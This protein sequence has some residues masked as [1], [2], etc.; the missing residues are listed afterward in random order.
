MDSKQLSQNSSVTVWPEKL[1][2]QREVDDLL[3]KKGVSSSETLDE[4]HQDARIINDKKKSNDKNVA[5]LVKKSNR[6]LTSISTHGWP[7]DFFP[8]TLNVEEGRI[9]IIIR[10]LF[11]SEVHSIDIKDISNIFINRTFIFSQLVI[12]SRTYEDN[13]IRINNLRTKEAVM[14]RRIIEGLRIFEHNH[15]NT[16]DFTSEELIAKLK[17]LST[18][19]IVT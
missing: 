5:S 18:T 10:H 17:E 16:A 19:E 9:T 2:T 11:S 12:V 14:V 1:Y 7:F 13:V 3:Q 6:I 15:I 8:D 4:L